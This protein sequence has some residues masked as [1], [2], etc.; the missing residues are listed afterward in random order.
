MRAFDFDFV[1]DSIDWIF[2]T[3][4]LEVDQ[5]GFEGPHCVE[6]DTELDGVLFARNQN[7]YLRF[8]WAHHW[9]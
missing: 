4:L 7:N 9:L 3:Y 1:E 5:I 6:K 8:Y 2:H